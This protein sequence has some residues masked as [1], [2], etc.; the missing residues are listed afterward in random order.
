MAAVQPTGFTL[1][2]NSVLN[3]TTLSPSNVLR[4]AQENK[5]LSLGL[6]L[7][8]AV[9]LT[10]RYILSPRRKLPPG[11]KGWPIIGSA[12]ELRDKQW[13][14]FTEWK[15]TYGDVIFING[16][17]Q[18]IV[19]LNTQK[20]AA[21][22]LDRRAGIYSDRPL[23]VVAS[24]IMTGGLLVVFTRYSDIWR[25]MRKAAHEGLNKGV[26][27]DFHTTQ[28]KEAL[29]LA[30]GGLEEPKEW[31]KHLRRTAAS[32]V[33]SVVYDQPT[34]EDEQDPRVK[35]IN[36][37][38]QRLT[39]AAYPGAHW[40]EF[41]PWM[42][43]LP[44]SIAKWKAEAEGWYRKDSAMFEGLF[45]SVKENVAKGDE[46]PSLSATLIRESGRH[47]L[48]NRENS[49][50]A[51]T[52]YAA[53]AETT[54]AVMSWWTLAMLA[55]PETMKRAQAE[56]D[57]VVGRERLPSFA[58]Y[59]HLPYV[60][61]MVKEALRWRPVD[62]VGLPHRSIEDDWYEGMFIPAGT[63]CIANVWHLN[64][65]PEI[66]GEDA[67]HFNPAR[68]LDAQGNVAPGPPDTKEESHVTYGFG[69]RLCVGRHVANNSLFIDIAITLWAANI[70]RPKGPDGKPVFLDVDG[71]V[72]DGL[73]V[74][75]IPFGVS[76]VPRFPEAVALLN[77]ERELKNET[78]LG[79]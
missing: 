72:E 77:S 78:G 22:L 20:A 50:L 48:T 41:F 35:D 59:N 21:D 67:H 6:L 39:R 58:D 47:G 3:T 18:D 2:F 36:D 7:G 54:S 64:R 40:V 12:L 33:L 51:G 16:A 15:K 1:P 70:E 31:D 69:R 56:L 8:A 11:P 34:I 68:H 60:R 49:W 19:I 79:A 28:T 27:R 13:L 42:K 53:G 38:V 71:F 29:L 65:D 63:I 9:L 55:Y 76:I 10:V 74:R 45:N 43:Y 66:Y 61:A 25:R 52:M 75:P 62:P 30:I 44:S 24:D 37:F 17:G 57:A 5:T 73:V 4:A 32:M 46:H 14:K 26:V 23:N